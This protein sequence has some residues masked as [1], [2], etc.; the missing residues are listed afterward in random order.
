MKFRAIVKTIAL[1]M[2]T[3][4]FVACSTSKEIIEN[5][6]EEGV[7]ANSNSDENVINL[8]SHYDGLDVVVEAFEKEYPEMKVNVKI[9]TFDEYEIE[10]KKSLIKDEGDADLFIIDSNNYGAFNSIRGLENLLKPEY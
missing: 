9:F 3:I 8:W 2:T 6:T 10:Y 1:I 7:G 5:K 4:T